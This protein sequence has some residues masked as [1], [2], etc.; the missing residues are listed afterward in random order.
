M[1]WVSLAERLLVFCARNAN[2][3]CYW[4]IHISGASA[5]L[6]DRAFT[7]FLAHLLVRY[8]QERTVPLGFRFAFARHRQSFSF[9][10]HLQAALHLHVVPGAAISHFSN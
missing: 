2:P 4:V 6:L 5:I 7:G 10:S 8:H 1:T 3:A 9:C